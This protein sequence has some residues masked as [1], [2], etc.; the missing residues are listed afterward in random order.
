LSFDTLVEN[1]D[2]PRPNNIAEF[3]QDAEKRRV[4]A[5]ACASADSRGCVAGFTTQL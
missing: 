4:A 1:Y 5:T 3:R 2:P